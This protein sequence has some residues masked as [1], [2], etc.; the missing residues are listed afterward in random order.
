MT[1]YVTA[2]ASSGFGA[3]PRKDLRKQRRKTRRAASGRAGRRFLG[4]LT[5]GLSLAATTK[6]TRQ[7]GERNILRRSAQ[8]SET[9]GQDIAL[10]SPLSSGGPGEAGGVI[11]DGLNAA[12]N[13]DEA[14]R[15][16]GITPDP[17]TASADAMVDLRSGA[18]GGSLVQEL[19]QQQPALY[20]ECE[21]LTAK[22]AE[23]QG[24]QLTDAM[25][26]AGI[27][28]CFQNVDQFRMNV[29]STGQSVDSCRPWYKRRTVWIVGAAV[30]AGA[31]ILKKK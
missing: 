10:Q 7:S 13:L 24:L 3:L 18:G 23:A 14:L 6:T 11:E 2:P 4:I 27:A 28:T 16:S 21:C 12:V 5:G 15:A 17:D 8:P 31:A 1:I 19:A 9:T 20:S 30:V 25:F 26:D 29:A 22:L